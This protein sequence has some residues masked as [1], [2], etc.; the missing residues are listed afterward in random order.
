MSKGT[1]TVNALSLTGAAR[2][3]YLPRTTVADLDKTA[4]YVTLMRPS[5]N[6]KAEQKNSEF[7]PE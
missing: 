5:G 7:S 4:S 3:S 2:N 6:V 1:Q